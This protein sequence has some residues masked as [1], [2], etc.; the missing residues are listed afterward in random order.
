M[1]ENTS[2]TMTRRIGSTVFKVNIFTKEDSS[3]TIEDKIM[4]L[5]QREGLASPED[6][7]MIN[8]PQMNRQSE[9]SA[10]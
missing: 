7:G 1:T 2:T 4:R 9:R 5:I 10:S 8:V 3:E 6:C